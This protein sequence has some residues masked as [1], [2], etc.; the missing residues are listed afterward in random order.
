MVQQMSKLVEDGLHIPMGQE[1]RAVRQ[2][3][4]EIPA[5]Q[6]QVRMEFVGGRAA[7]DQRI[8]PRAAALVFAWIPV[9]VKS[10]QLFAVFVRDGVEAR[11]RIPNRNSGLMN[12]ADSV[13]PMHEVEQSFDYPLQRKI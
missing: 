5:D 1:R 8:H 9:S 13:K 11:L 3:R 4:S 2:G 12:D 7:G 6:P 10:A